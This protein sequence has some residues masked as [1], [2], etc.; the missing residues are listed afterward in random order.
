MLQGRLNNSCLNQDIKN[1]KTAV[2]H[3]SCCESDKKQTVAMAAKSPQLRLALLAAVR[4]VWLCV[5]LWSAHRE[6]R[7]PFDGWML[8]LGVN[9]QHTLSSGS[10]AANPPGGEARSGLRVVWVVRRDRG[11]PGSRGINK[12]WHQVAG[13]QNR[14]ARAVRV[15]YAT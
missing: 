4:S 5:S 3:V 1:C 6:N 2:R 12:R 13:P 15:L 7:R 9:T 14:A 11:C 8:P 10:D